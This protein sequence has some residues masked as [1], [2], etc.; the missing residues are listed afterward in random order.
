VTGEAIEIVAAD[1]AILRGRA[2][3]GIVLAVLLLH[4]PGEER[5]LD[6]WLPLIPYLLGDGAA[7][8]AVDLR[9]HGA[10]DG[11]WSPDTARDDLAAMIAW[12]RHFS[13]QTVLVAA[14]GSAPAALRAA[15]QGGIAG[16]VLLS[17]SDIDAPDLRGSGVAKLIFAGS[18]D[19]A[20]R[21][22]ADRLR[23]ISI[24]PALSVLL[25][26]EIQGTDLLECGVAIQIR[27]HTLRFL[28][29]RRME[30][31]QAA[32]IRQAPDRFLSRLGIVPKGVEE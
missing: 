18:H 9:G 30:L 15:E 20:A 1:G 13:D 6:D 32:A 23:A 8:A 27:E 21:A 14:G 4:A 25:P 31:T 24:G 3:D 7:I 17:A 2:W 11:E 29:E 28:R 26:T 16:L 10:S 12:M 22:A 5:D 19:P